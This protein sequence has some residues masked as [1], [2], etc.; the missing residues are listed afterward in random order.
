MKHLKIK[1]D[2]YE[3]SWEEILKNV[4][5]TLNKD[6]K[7]AIVW[8]NWVW[9]TTIL[10]IITWEIK[11]FDWTIENIGSVS[12]GYLAQIY[13]DDENK[14]VYEELKDGFVEINK[15]EKE[16]E[17]LEKKLKINDEE[18]QNEQNPP[19]PLYKGGNSSVI[20]AEAWIY[21]NGQNNLLDPSA[22]HEDDNTDTDQ[23]WKDK[24]KSSKER[25]IENE[26]ILQLYSEKLEQFNNYGWYNYNSILMSVASGLGIIDLLKSKLTEISWWQRTKVALWKILIHSPDILFLDE[27]TNFID[28]T[29]LEWLE[30]Y[31]QNKWKNWYVIV[32]HDREFL[33][34]TC[35]KTFELQ[36]ARA[37]NFYYWNYT[38]YVEEREK[39]EA[40]LREDFERQADWIAS[41]EKLVNRF[42]AWS[43]AGWAKSR[44]KMLD[45]LEKIEAPYIV[46]KTKFL[47]QDA[48]EVWEKVLTFKQVFIWR[49]D[50]LFFINDLTLY[51]WQKIWIVWENWVGKSTF[52]KSIIGQIE[53]LD[54]D[55]KKAKWLKI[56]YYSQMHK[57]L[58]I[59]KTIRENFIDNW[60]NYTSE[61]LIW[62][63]NHYLFEYADIEK[64]VW[65]LSWGQLSKL[66]F[67]ILWQKEYDLLI[68]DEPT[69][70][71][72][73]DTRESLEEALKKY[74]WTLLFISH[75]RYFV[76]KLATN[77]WIIK[78]NELIVSYGNYEDYKYKE[79]YGINMDMSLFDEVWQ[80]NFVL[81][82][83]LGE[84]EFKRLKNRFK[85][86]G[87]K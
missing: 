27:P 22:K 87:R 59:E 81:E 56:G 71:L 37:L 70:H 64:K 45:K 41:Q 39:R 52:I 83:K 4:E 57:E 28:M 79:E 38:H 78:N 66:A 14:T 74:N 43:R 6:D 49:K 1:I 47:F 80:L 32:S 48:Q 36:K 84:K 17:E 69:N 77:I 12:L 5:F 2:K 16:L 13:N 34:K 65:D 20:P 29:S 25:I 11:D 82:E 73:Y 23:K 75:D 63:L 8:W 26:N 7:I 24:Q 85:K 76:N 44:E 40:K 10:K 60:F 18:S 61:H 31:L 30:S 72:D 54:W 9:K 51:K 67:A 50:P 33:D 58:K 55:F 62:I 86:F 21:K 15:L 46:K 35:E 3:V 42:R 19:S 68:L 53:F